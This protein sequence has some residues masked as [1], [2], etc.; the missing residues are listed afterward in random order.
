[1]VAGGSGGTGGMEKSKKSFSLGGSSVNKV[2]VKIF[3]STVGTEGVL[4]EIGEIFG[5]CW[6]LLG[7][8]GAGKE[9]MFSTV[10]L[11]GAGRGVITMGAA[12]MGLTTTGD[13]VGVLSSSVGVLSVFSSGVS[14]LSLLLGG[15]WCFQ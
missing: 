2:S 3:E 13:K 7:V 5:V 6:L 15:D 9:K 14:S 11:R 12:S 8:G 10:G 4:T 1:M